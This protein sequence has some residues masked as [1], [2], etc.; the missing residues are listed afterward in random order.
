MESRRVFYVAHMTLGR[1]RKVQMNKMLRYD[2]Y[3]CMRIGKSVAEEV[4][5]DEGTLS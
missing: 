1:S 3:V 5:G 4:E 2:L